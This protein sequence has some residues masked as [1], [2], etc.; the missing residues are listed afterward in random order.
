MRLGIVFLI[1]VVACGHSNG[2]GDDSDGGIGSGSGS[3][4]AA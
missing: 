4:A 3:V 1:G 2:N